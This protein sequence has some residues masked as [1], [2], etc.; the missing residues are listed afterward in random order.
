MAVRS[1]ADRGRDVRLRLLST[2]AELITELGWTAVSTRI[3]ADRAGVTPGLV[4]YHFP[5]LQALLRDAALGMISDLLSS[6]EATLENAT[7]LDAGLDLM[8]SSLGART[9]TE[10]TSLLFTETYLAAA[11]DETLRGELIAL[12]TEFREQLA[13]WLAEHAALK[14]DDTASVLAAAIDGVILHRALNP[15][16]TT[17][18]VAPL[19]RGLITSGAAANQT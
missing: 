17:A 11:R 6:T 18:T 19:L 12:V 5:S 16:L 13:Q 7:T 8:L 1:A 2:A 4:H 14:P 10:S 15:D 9:G 3:L